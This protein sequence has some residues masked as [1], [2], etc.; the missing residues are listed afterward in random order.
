MKTY[1]AIVLVCLIYFGV[2][3]YLLTFG[4]AENSLGLYALG[5]FF[6]IFLFLGLDGVEF[7]IKL[8]ARKQE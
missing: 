2:F 8:F 1:L 5:L 4:N 6:G 3:Y 7:T